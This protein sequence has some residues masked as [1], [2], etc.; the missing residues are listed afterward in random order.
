MAVLR[1]FVRTVAGGVLTVWHVGPHR[2]S[3]ENHGN[4]VYRCRSGVS[5]TDSMSG[6]QRNSSNFIL[7]HHTAFRLSGLALVVL[8][9][10]L[11]FTFNVYRSTLCPLTG[12][13]SLGDSIQ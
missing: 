13:E 12:S 10:L 1:R 2:V 4:V 8:D 9:S 6:R 7:Y 11:H 3:A 5:E